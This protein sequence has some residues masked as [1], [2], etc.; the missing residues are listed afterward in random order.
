MRT[1][2]W[3]G[4]TSATGFAPQALPTARTAAGAPIAR[5]ISLV[6]ASLA[7]R[8]AAQLVPHAALEHRAAD[9][10]RHAGEAALA[11]DEGADLALRSSG[12][13][14]SASSAALNSSASRRFER[15]RI[16]PSLTAQTPLSVA[17]T[18]TVP[19]G[20]AKEQ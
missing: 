7:A 18:S 10:E 16:G 11:G 19:S 17:A 13:R 14:S 9:V 4:T 8:D 3:Q 15:L 12:M 2:R 5:A 1:A 6:G 20:V